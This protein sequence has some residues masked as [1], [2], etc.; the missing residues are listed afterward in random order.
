MPSFT[1]V[2]LERLPSSR[3]EDH[4]VHTIRHSQRRCGNDLEAAG[5]AIAFMMAAT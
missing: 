5:G 4:L 1:L 3:G 2:L